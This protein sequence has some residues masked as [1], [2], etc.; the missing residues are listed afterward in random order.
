MTKDAWVVDVLDQQGEDGR[1]NPFFSRNLN[2][3]EME[4]VV[5]F[6]L[7]LRGKVVGRDEE[8]VVEWMDAKKGKFSNKFFYNFWGR[9]EQR[10]SL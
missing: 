4:R 8:D 5:D 3:W 6:L 2:D 9:K 1:W 10:S 7:R